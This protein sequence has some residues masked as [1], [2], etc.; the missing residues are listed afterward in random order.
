MIIYLKSGQTIDMGDIIEAEDEYGCTYKPLNHSKSGDEIIN[1]LTDNGVMCF[2]NTNNEILEVKS[3][4][5][6]A[7]RGDLK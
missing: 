2:F 7:I 6:V 4:D 1:L 5:I 3:G